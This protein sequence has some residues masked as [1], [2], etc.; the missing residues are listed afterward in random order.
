MW[1]DVGVSAMCGSLLRRKRE[2]E[3]EREKRRRRNKGEGEA[4]MHMLRC[5]IPVLRA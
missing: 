1:V 5:A 2:A 3:R 4:A